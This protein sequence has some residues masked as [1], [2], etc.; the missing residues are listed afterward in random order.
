MDTSLHTY[1]GTPTNSSKALIKVVVNNG[2]IV[3]DTFEIID[4]LRKENEILKN[5]MMNVK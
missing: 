3:V 1:L 5:K 4:E 2:S